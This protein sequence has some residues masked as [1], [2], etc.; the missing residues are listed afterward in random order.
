[1]KIEKQIFGT[2][3]HRLVGEETADEV[4]KRYDM[5]V[6]QQINSIVVLKNNKCTYVVKPAD[7]YEKIAL[8]LGVSETIL[9]DLN[10]NGTLFI[11]RNLVVNP[12]ESK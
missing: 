2:L 4:A 3:I 8:K 9:R 7:T 12:L 6:E 10:G 1:M 5:H 11:G